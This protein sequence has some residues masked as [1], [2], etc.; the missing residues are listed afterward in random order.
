MMMNSKSRDYQCPINAHY[1]FFS[2]LMA[3]S[4][5]RTKS[6]AAASVKPKATVRFFEDHQTFFQS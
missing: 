6:K 2:F 5:F 1:S 4:R 3:A